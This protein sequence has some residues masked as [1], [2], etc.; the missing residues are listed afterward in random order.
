MVDGTKKIQKLYLDKQYCFN[1]TKFNK[2]IKTVMERVSIFQTSQRFGDGESPIPV[3][4]YQKITPESQAEVT[5]GFDGFP[6][7]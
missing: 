4:K 5:V 7:L 3:E 1:Y 6:P 2:L